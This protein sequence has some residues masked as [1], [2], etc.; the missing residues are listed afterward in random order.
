MFRPLSSSFLGVMVRQAVGFACFV[1]MYSTW[2]GEGEGG[3][4][5]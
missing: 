2:E 4:G 5:F 1:F 3:Q